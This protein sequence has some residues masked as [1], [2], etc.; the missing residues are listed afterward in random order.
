MHPVV[1]L[2]IMRPCT[3]YSDLGSRG[4]PPNITHTVGCTVD[5]ASFMGVGRSKKDA[6]K[7]AAAEVLK[8]LFQ[9]APTA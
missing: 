1:L 3:T 6:R 5:G 2:S 4:V 8:A 9:L 7:V